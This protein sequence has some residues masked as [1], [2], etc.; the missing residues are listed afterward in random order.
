MEECDCLAHE[1]VNI[2]LQVTR[3]Y[4]TSSQLWDELVYLLRRSDRVRLPSKLSHSHG[5]SGN[6]LSGGMPVSPRSSAASWQS[7][8]STS[9]PFA[10][11]N[12]SPQSEQTSPCSTAASSSTS[13]K[14][15]TS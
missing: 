4:A 5:T 1:K 2:P 7:W 12:R 15:S 3:V 6:L 9:I 14:S 13:E 11:V 10:S 8:Q